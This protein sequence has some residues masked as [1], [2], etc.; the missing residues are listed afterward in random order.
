MP[1]VRCQSNGKPGYK[2]GPSGKCY[3]YSSEQGA[4]AA[5]AKAERQGRA[6]EANKRRPKD[7][8]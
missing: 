7:G 1:V 3:T 5:R 4:A 6:I 2:W 8:S